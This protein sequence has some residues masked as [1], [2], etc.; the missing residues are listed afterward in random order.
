MIVGDVAYGKSEIIIRAIY[1][2]SKS[3]LQSLVLVPTTLLARQHYYNFLNRFEP[4][5]IKIKQLSRFISI[6]EKAEIYNGLKSGQIDC[7]IG[8]HALLSEKII[9]KNLGLIVIDEEQ[10]FGVKTKEKL[11]SI[12]LNAHII[13]MSATPIPRTLQLSLSGIRDLS[14]ILT[15]PFER[16]SIRTYISLFD[17]ITIKEAIKREVI[18]RNGGVFWV[19]PRKRDIPFLESFLKEELPN[20]NYVVAHGQLPTKTLEKRVSEFYDKKVPILISTNIIESGLDLPNVNT[21]IIHRAN[22]FGLSQLH[23]LR[24]RVGRLAN[25]RGYAYLTYQKET[26]LNENSSKRLNII[27]TFDK[28]GSGFNIASSDMDLRGSGNIVGIDQSGFIK[29][30]GIELYNQLLEEEITKQKNILFNT[31]EF[32]KH[33]L[34]QPI[35]KLPE[36]IFIPDDY[37]ND[38]DV[39]ISLYKRISLINN[40]K[41]KESIIIEMID[42]FGKLPKE[43]ENLFKL[44]EI[45][46]LCYQ[47]NIEKIDYGKKGVLFTFFKSKPNNP[48]KL[49]KLSVNFKKSKIKIRPDNKVFYDLSNTL[50]KDKFYLVKKLIK[51]FI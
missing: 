4:F 25:K 37:I 34:F 46:I 1:L 22:M 5:G 27:N 18:G 44:I 38:I 6:K 49:L 20:I 41:E 26:D 24:G 12:S 16:L 29:E 9:F 23:Q 17:K 7:V 15:P 40:Q 48:N 50:I 30:V 14:L 2:A 8:T 13:S 42:R 21:I 31:K 10:H 11:K 47:E 36:S 39:K 35:I 51:Q 28:L 45:K 32:T 33:N 3:S 43:I 19:T